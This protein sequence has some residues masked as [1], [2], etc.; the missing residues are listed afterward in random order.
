MAATPADLTK[1][2]QKSFLT[3]LTVSI[4]IASISKVLTR[5]RIQACR[6]RTTRG[7]SVLRSGICCD[8]QPALSAWLCSQSGPDVRRVGTDIAL[9]RWGYP[10]SLGCRSRGSPHLTRMGH[11]ESPERKLKAIQRPHGWLPV[12]SADIHLGKGIGGRSDQRY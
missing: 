11:S 12:L 4:L 8:S 2:G 1:S 3:C 6:C 5:S 7:D 9:L 10:S